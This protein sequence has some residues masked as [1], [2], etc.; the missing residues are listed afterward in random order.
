MKISSLYCFLLSAASAL[1]DA[2]YSVTVSGAFNPQIDTMNGNSRLSEAQKDVEE[3]K[4]IMLDNLN[5]AEERSGKLKELE[6]RADDLLV[7]G[8]AFSKTATKVKQKK[9]WENIK[10]KVV[11]AAVAAAV[12]LG[13]ILAVALSFSNDDNG[14]DASTTT[15][16]KAP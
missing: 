6:T 3:V 16:T 13:I 9:R 10:Y 12:L 4:G 8:K 14:K 1:S 7:K 2:V 5:K 15:T 11:I